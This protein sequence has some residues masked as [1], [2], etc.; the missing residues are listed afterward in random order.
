HSW[1]SYTANKINKLLCKEGELWMHESFDH[2]IRSPKQ[3]ERIRKYIE[4]NPKVTHASSVSNTVTQPSWLSNEK[5]K[6]DACDTERTPYNFKRHCIENCLYGVDIDSSAIDI[7]KL[8]FWLSLVVDEEDITKIKPLPNLDYKLVCG[9]SLLKVERDLFNAELFNQ[10]EELK[11]KYFNETDTNKKLEL[12]KQIDKLI[13]ELVTQPSRL[14]NNEHKQDACD[15]I[16]DFEV[17][18]SEVFH[19]KK[20]FDVVIGNPPYVKE[21]TFRNAFDGLRESPY[22]KGKMDIWYLFA[23]KGI[24]LLKKETGIL[25][26]IAQNNW[27]TSYGASIMRNKVIQDTQIIQML[28]F[29]S[30]MIFESSDI[31]TMIMIFRVDPRSDNYK[32]DYRRLEGNNLNLNDMLDLLNCNQNSKT[33]YLKPTIQRNKLVDKFLTFSDTKIEAILD[34]LSE[35]GNFRLMEN[36]VAKGIHY[37]QDRVNKNMQKILENRFNIGEGIF[38]LSNKEK[39]DIPFTE[40]EL[41]LIKPSYTTKELGRYYANRKNSEWVIYKVKK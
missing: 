4:N 32:F 19:E 22:Y 39:N 14:T 33:I 6:Q 24:D 23:C 8:R 20:G 41:E 40:K 13:K 25:T 34:K 2:I 35:E 15:T 26:F 18:F 9:N 21:H 27:V 16:F 12:K 37:D 3:F 38:A 31:Q 7:A 11:P 1:K 36:E 5:H 29:G 10:L 30:Y 17:Y 28:D